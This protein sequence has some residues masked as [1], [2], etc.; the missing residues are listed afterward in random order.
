MAVTTRNRWLF[1]VISL[2]LLHA[3]EALACTACFGDPDSSQTQGMNAA[4]LTLLAVTFGVLL[5]GAGVMMQIMVRAGR[6]TNSDT[7]LS[8][9]GNA[10]WQDTAREEA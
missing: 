10:G 7:S 1:A 2:A 6:G 8:V 5:G 9:E 4:I 3:P